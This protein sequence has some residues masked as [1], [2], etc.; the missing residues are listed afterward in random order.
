MNDMD[1]RK[2]IIDKLYDFGFG[3]SITRHEIFPLA[4]NIEKGKY[5]INEGSIFKASEDIKEFD[6]R[7]VSNI[8]YEFYIL[9]FDVALEKPVIEIHENS[10]LGIG[11][12]SC[13]GLRECTEKEKNLADE[14][15]NLYK[16]DFNNVEYRIRLAQRTLDD[17][18]KMLKELKCQKSDEK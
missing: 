1:K 17:A 2:E 5:Y 7:I 6:S 11:Y 10:Q 8:P 15:Y 3:Y 13:F 4:K 16:T 14:I 18:M 9:R 12:Y